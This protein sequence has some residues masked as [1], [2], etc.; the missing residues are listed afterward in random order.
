VGGDTIL[1]HADSPDQA[2]QIACDGLMTT[3]QA[4]DEEQKRH[5]QAHAALARLASVGPVERID[6]AIK[7]ASDQ[8]DAFVEDVA[9]VRPLRGD[10]IALATGGFKQ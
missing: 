7:P 1:V 4:M 5:K 3:L 9:A 8:S 2:K 10:D 6:Q